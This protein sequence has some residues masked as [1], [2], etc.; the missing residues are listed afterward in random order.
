M[1]VVASFVRR[2]FAK[3]VR[4][5]ELDIVLVILVVLWIVRNWEKHIRV[6]GCGVGDH[7]CAVGDAI[8]MAKDREFQI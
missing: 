5:V 7:C 6:W 1:A 3:R 8:V 4:F 2:C